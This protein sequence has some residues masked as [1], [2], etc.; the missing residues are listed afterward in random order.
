MKLSECPKRTRLRLT[1][2]NLP[3][4]NQLRMQE[5]GLRAGNEAVVT[6]KAGFGGVVL[7]VAGSRV[8][9]DHRSARLIEAEV[10]A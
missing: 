8:A 4:K 7:N 10:L 3:A 1:Q 9:V 6:Q 5:L 2:V